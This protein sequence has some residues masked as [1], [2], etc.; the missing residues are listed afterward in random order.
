MSSKQCQFPFFSAFHPVAMAYMQKLEHPPCQY[1]RLSSMVVVEGNTLK[2]TS[3]LISE[4]L[5]ET[6]PTVC[7]YFSFQ[8]SPVSDYELYFKSS[9]TYFQDWVKLQPRDENVRVNCF[10]SS[11]NLVSSGYL[12]VIAEDEPTQILKTKKYKRHVQRHKPNRTLSVILLGVDSMS[13]Q[14]F[15]RTMPKTREFLLESLGALEFYKY[16][17]VGYETFRNLMPILAGYEEIDLENQSKFS[18]TFNS[19][20]NYIWNSYQKAGYRTQIVLD[21]KNITTFHWKKRGFSKK[22]GDFYNRPVVIISD[23]EDNSAYGE[24]CIGDTPA[25]VYHLDYIMRMAST[26]N[27]SITPYFTFAFLA[28][29]THDDMNMA[30]AGDGFFASFFESLHE[31]ML[32]QNTVIVFFS[33][34][35]T[36]LGP[37]R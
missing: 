8:R 30:S 2:M 31:K 13:K 11:S 27:N 3:D 37:F 4:K 19:S 12:S 1:K 16:S 9:A 7:S 25:T 33:D 17:V 22:P 24:Y 5:K 34:H 18:N 14:N 15:E 36:R 32:L 28:S 20:I 21:R 23:E 35:G 26:F 29:L 10:D 6:A